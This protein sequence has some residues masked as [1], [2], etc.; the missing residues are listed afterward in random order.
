MNTKK[1]MDLTG[2]EL[3]DL[4]KQA[5]R[6]EREEREEAQEKADEQFRADMESGAF[7]E[8]FEAEQKK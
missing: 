6:E 1:V 3:R 2:D 5:I 4:I 8:R 7:W